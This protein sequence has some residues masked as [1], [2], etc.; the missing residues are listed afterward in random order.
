[1]LELRYQHAR[2]DSKRDRENVLHIFCLQSVIETATIVL[3][4][5]DQ[6]IAGSFRSGTLDG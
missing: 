3:V 5:C 4:V 2:T 1:M 6:R